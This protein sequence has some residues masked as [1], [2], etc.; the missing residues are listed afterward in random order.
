MPETVV[1]GARTMHTTPGA[2][3]RLQCCSFYLTAKIGACCPASSVVTQAYIRGA[4]ERAGCSFMLAVPLPEKGR[5]RKT[6]SDTIT[7]PLQC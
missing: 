4:S 2:G 5:R 1:W 6:V 7:T 3:A